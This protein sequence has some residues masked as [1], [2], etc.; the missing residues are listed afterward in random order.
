MSKNHKIGYVSHHISTHRARTSERSSPSHS[1]H[2]IGLS[3]ILKDVLTLEKVVYGWMFKNHKIGHV[4]HHISTHRACT[5]KRSSPS[6]SAHRIGLSTRSNDVLTVEEGVCGWMFKNGKIGHVFR[7]ISETR[8]LTLS[9]LL[10]TLQRQLKVVALLAQFICEGPAP[11][12]WLSLY[13]IVRL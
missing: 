12:F 9:S 3:T 10:Y 11:T 4:F 13:P 5:S 6:D 1:A 2:R 7:H 8:A